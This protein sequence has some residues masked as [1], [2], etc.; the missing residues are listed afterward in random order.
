MYRCDFKSYSKNVINLIIYMHASDQFCKHL[1]IHA[2][3]DPCER[4]RMQ[5]D[6]K[7]SA[8]GN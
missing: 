2:T 5:L 3:I 1:V 8:K 6:G 4:S 7:R